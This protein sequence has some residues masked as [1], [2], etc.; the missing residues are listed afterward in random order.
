[1]CEQNTDQLKTAPCLDAR[2]TGCERAFRKTILAMIVQGGRPLPPAELAGAAGL[3]I[4]ESDDLL[5]A[6][7]MKGLLVRNS[8][9]EIS[10]VYPVSA[11]PTQHRVTLADGRSFSAMCAIDALGCAFEFAQNAMVTSS[12]GHCQK[13]LTVSLER[14]EVTRADPDTIQ[15]LHVDLD[16]YADWAASC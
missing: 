11:L 8:G 15:I 9:G 4:Q 10:G 5:N 12:C 3:S 1:M 13:P 16:Q 6:L 2:L 14:G 7:Q